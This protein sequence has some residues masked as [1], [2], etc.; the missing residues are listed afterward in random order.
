MKLI[1]RKAKALGVFEERLTNLTIR[2][3]VER[4]PQVAL[5]VPDVI[6]TIRKTRILK[7][8]YNMPV[9]KDDTQDISRPQKQA[10]PSFSRLKS[11]E[12]SGSSQPTE[13]VQDRKSYKRQQ[14]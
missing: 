11:M 9:E 7:K 13:N 8:I 4:F 10:K 6:L 2:F 3:G 12:L 14:S 1:Q 5:N